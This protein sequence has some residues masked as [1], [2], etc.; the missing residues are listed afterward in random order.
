MHAKVL[1]MLY[2]HG[3]YILRH[4]GRKTPTGTT[5]PY[6][7]LDRVSDLRLIK[8]QPIPRPVS[9][10]T[11]CNSTNI[12]VLSVRQEFSIDGNC[13]PPVYWFLIPL[14]SQQLL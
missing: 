2:I 7:L 11:N 5:G 6:R 3:K 10:N 1:R 12:M 9:T 4:G 13:K 14:Q 8:G